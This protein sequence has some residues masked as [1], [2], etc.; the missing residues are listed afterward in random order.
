MPAIITGQFSRPTR[1]GRLPASYLHGDALAGR[2][3]ALPF[4]R[5]VL[6]PRAT[7]WPEPATCIGS[8]SIRSTWG[9]APGVS[10]NVAATLLIL[11]SALL[12]A[13]VNAIVKTS[14]DGLLTRGFMNATALVVAAPL[15]LFVPFPNLELWKILLLA[16]LIH[17]IYPFLLVGSYRY[18][19]LSSVFPLARGVAPL[20]VLGLSWAGLGEPVPIAKILCIAVIASGVAS[21]AVERGVSESPAVRRGMMLAV[22]T[23]MIV[24]VYTVIDGIG[25][26][27]AP[28]PL[29]Y[30]VWLFV[31]DGAFVSSCTLAV[32]WR[33]V[34]P[35]F[36]RSWR[37]TLMGGVLGVLTY[38]LALFALAIGSVAEIA[39]L[40]ETSVVFAAL[41]GTL[42]L[43]EAFGRRRVL[44]AL[45][46]A[47][48]AIG[49]QLDR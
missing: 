31:L 6:V 8:W 41:I 39:A 16:T 29:T 32:R 23:G 21:F 24:A 37:T 19:D 27:A 20:G 17:G 45:L 36:K 48:G 1:C 46:I 11:I 4:P 38:G 12:H 28:T 2:P 13:V 25:L 10:P 34:A 47:A 7:Q 35:F 43:G 5:R 15:T 42:F 3:H 44:A 22:M 9:P 18:G 26:R 14:D 33:S 40:R 49:L 30:I